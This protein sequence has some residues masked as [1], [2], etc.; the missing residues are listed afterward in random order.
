LPAIDVLSVVMKA[1]DVTRHT[2]HLMMPTADNIKPIILIPLPDDAV[3]Y[4]YH[5]PIFIARLRR[6][7]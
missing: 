3:I 7:R 4:R 2:I 1:L 5:R 6:Y